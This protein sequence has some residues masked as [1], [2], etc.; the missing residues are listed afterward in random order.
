MCETINEAIL[1]LYQKIM[2]ERVE[3]K[4]VNNK[5]KFSYQYID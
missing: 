5:I 3:R 1:L 2:E 4:C